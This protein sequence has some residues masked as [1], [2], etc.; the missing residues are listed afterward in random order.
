MFRNNRWKSIV[1]LTLALVIG[2]VCQAQSTTGTITGTVTDIRN[3]VVVGARLTLTNTLTG[4]VKTS[5][6]NGTGQYVLGF[7]PVGQYSL[8]VVEQGFNPERQDNIDISA[9]QGIQ[10]NFTLHVAPRFQP[11]R[12]MSFR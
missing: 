6:T 3:A 2:R 4:L 1:I 7:I 8:Q 5:V 12:L 11:R 9:A 10:I